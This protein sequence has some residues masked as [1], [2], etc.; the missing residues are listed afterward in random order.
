MII[1]QVERV[2][3]IQLALVIGTFLTFESTCLNSFILIFYHEAL[4]DGL[5]NRN[6]NR[7]REETRLS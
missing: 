3:T 1:W 5:L 7:S 2:Y 4:T 6:Q